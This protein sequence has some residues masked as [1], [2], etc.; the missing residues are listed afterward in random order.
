METRVEVLW[1]KLWLVLTKPFPISGPRR[2][3]LSQ[4]A[5]SRFPIS[6]NE[7]DQNLS[8]WLINLTSFFYY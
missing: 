1:L 3:A 8:G 6:A 2:L 4:A 7:L 5:N